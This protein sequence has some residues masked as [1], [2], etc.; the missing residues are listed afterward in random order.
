MSHRHLLSDFLILNIFFL[1]L[2]GTAK[3]LAIELILVL[4]I[5][6]SKLL[7]LMQPLNVAL[8]GQPR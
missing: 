7:V 2:L 5:L 8:S 3:T 1:C 6:E 4:L